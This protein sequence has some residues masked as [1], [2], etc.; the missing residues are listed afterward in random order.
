MTVGGSSQNGLNDAPNPNAITL[1]GPSDTGA[2]SCE[3]CYDAVMSDTVDLTL[4]AGSLTEITRDVRLMRLQLDNMASR[5]SAQEG[6][7]GG[8][9]GRIASLEQSFH[10]LVGEVSRGFGQQQQQLTRLEKRLDGLDAGLS[11]LRTDLVAG[12]ASIIAAIAAK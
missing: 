9:D 3:R 10:D 6:R 5:L 12:T 11:T 7:I 1:A 4:L 8:I 2:A